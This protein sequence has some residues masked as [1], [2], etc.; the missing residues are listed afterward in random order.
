VKQLL[1]DA[2]LRY[3]YIWHEDNGWQKNMILNKSIVASQSDYIVFIDGD[4]LLQKHFV[5]EHYKNRAINHMLVGR[6]VNL[7][8][9]VSEKL[10][11]KIIKNG[12]LGTRLLLDLL[13]ESIIG[14]AKDLE[15]GFYFKNKRLIAWINAKDRKLKGCNFSI[16]KQDL[17]AVNGFDERFYLPAAGEDT[18]LD[19]RLR[20]N[21]VKGK[22]LRNLAIQYHLFHSALERHPDRY[23]YYDENN[24]NEVTYTPYGIDKKEQSK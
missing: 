4:C 16:H 19:A 21:G 22:G 9:R 12:Y 20:R 24:A 8:S 13:F 18:D 10:N 15:Q 2:G 17:L 14:K 1:E 7:S 23:F 11:P 3:Q 5:E 6:R